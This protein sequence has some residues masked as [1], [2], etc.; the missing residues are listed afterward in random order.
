[1]KPYAHEYK[2]M[3]LAPFSEH[4]INDNCINNLNSYL[5]LMTG[6]ITNNRIP[7]IIYTFSKIFSYT[8]FDVV[9][10]SIQKIVEDNLVRVSRACRVH[11]I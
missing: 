2:M 11:N 10:S 4:L 1:M 3:G 9:A 7:M 6:L 8:R 5:K